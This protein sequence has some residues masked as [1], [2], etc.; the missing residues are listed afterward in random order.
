MDALYDGL[1]MASTILAGCLLHR[2]LRILELLLD[3]T[4]SPSSLMACD[5]YSD[6]VMNL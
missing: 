1:Q 4:M 6:H 5:F 2:L 3:H